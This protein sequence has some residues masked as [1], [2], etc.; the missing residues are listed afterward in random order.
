[1]PKPKITVQLDKTQN[2]DILIFKEA[3]AQPNFCAFFFEQKVKWQ[4]NKNQASQIYN[5]LTL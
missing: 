2:I 4:K 1:M 5:V 3:T